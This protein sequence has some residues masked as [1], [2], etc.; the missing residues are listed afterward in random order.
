[1]A[2]P[3]LS[4]T[5]TARP[6]GGAGAPLRRDS[7]SSQVG[8]DLKWTPN[9]DNVMD[10]TVRPDFSQV[11]SDTAQISANERFALF[12]PERRPFFL[13]G[14][15]LFSTPIQAIYTRRI[16]S[17]DWGALVTGKGAGI[18]YTLLSGT[19]TIASCRI[20]INWERPAVSSSSSS[21]THSNASNPELPSPP[22]LNLRV[23]SVPRGW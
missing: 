3:Y 2:A 12:F 5:D 15:N 14:V 17:P 23:L 4:A 9:A 19:A 10:L 11:E 21:L 20:W 13:E 6:G 22:G 8:A 18:Q 1:M 7:F 16:T